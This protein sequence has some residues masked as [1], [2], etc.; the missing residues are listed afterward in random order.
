MRFGDDK[1]GHE[2]LITLTPL[3]DVVFI[4]LVFFMLASSFLDWRAVDLRLTGA[5]SGGPSPTSVMLVV[6]RADGSL[7]LDG[8][9]ATQDAVLARTREN[10]DGDEPFSIVVRP[11]DKV[12]LQQMVGLIDVLKA[13]GAVDIA[14]SRGR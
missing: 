1:A 10:V 8:E 7:T 13:A 4:L 12:E 14:L 6:L 5:S 3:I 11:E 9:P 2:R